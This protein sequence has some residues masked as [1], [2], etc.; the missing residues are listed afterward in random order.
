[1]P[2]FIAAQFLGALAAL[3]MAR[4]LLKEAEVRNA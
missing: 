4:V 1:M 3:A 2:G